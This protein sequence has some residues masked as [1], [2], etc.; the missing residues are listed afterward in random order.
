MLV[1]VVAAD[2]V[3]FLGFIV[4]LGICLIGR[5]LAEVEGLTL[6]LFAAMLQLMPGAGS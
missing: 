5:V 3:V 4:T 6:F 2:S 1:L